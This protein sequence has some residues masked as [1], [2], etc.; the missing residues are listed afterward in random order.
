MDK[1]NE[2]KLASDRQIDDLGAWTMQA[3]ARGI[4]DDVLDEAVKVD[5]LHEMTSAQAGD[6]IARLRAAVSA[7]EAEWRRSLCRPRPPSSGSEGGG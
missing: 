3:D 4:A 2:Q 1:T 6:W 5:W 7:H